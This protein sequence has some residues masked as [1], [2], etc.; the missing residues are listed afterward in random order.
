MSHGQFRQADIER[1]IRAA[2]NAGAVIKI[3]LRT[4]ATVIVPKLDIDE[5][6]YADSL[7][8]DHAR[9]GKENWDDIED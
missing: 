2:R 9:D 6:D 8:G 5:N 3:D 7:P 1:L 4:L